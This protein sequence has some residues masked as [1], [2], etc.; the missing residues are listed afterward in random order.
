MTKIKEWASELSTDGD[1]PWFLGEQFSMVDLAL[2]PWACRVFLLDHYK[3][4][5]GVPHAESEGD[6]EVWR[7]WRRWFAAIVE[8]ESVVNTLS[9]AERYVAVY[10]RYSEDTTGSGVGQATRGGR[11]LP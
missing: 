9:D 6:D 1:G 5:S 3:G 7:R 10:Q 4:G 11:G 8:R 2:A